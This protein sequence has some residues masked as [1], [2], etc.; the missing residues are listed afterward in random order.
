MPP[1]KKDEV[2]VQAVPE[3]EEPAPAVPEQEELAPP[4]PAS[5]EAEPLKL[6]P[7]QVIYSVTGNITSLA[8]AGERYPV[9]HG[10]VILPATDR[11]YDDL[12]QAG[13]LK[14]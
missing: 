8:H 6:E 5:E 4:A 7:G 2:I 14:S 9:L 12:I 13:I 11:W 1:K 3:Q 10:K